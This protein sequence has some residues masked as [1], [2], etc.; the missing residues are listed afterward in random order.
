MSGHEDEAGRAREDAAW[1]DII[2][3]YGE[4]PAFPDT[5][6]PDA[7]PEPAAVEQAPAFEVPLELGAATW[8]D[9]GHFVPE[10][11]PLAPRPTGPRG[12][13]WVTL[14]AV[15]V[16]AL[17]LTLLSIGLSGFLIFLLAAAF[18]GAFGYLVATMDDHRDPDSGWDDGAVL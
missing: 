17:V 8:A 7:L 18:V 2:D 9:E 3:G 14:F 12:L 13:A 15:P 5:P 16:I 4:R 11:P 1:Q 10:P 6:A